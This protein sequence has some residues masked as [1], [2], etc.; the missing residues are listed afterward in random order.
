[1]K[2]EVMV[3]LMVGVNVK[4]GFVA[5]SARHCVPLSVQPRFVSKTAWHAQQ[6]VHEGAKKTYARSDRS[7]SWG[8]YMLCMS[9]HELVLTCY[10]DLVAVV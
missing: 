7:E 10:F 8:M 1:M 9:C 5:L 6:G 2:L 4:G 3:K